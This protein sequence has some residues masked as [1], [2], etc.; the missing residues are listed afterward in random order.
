MRPA[1]R[2]R[3]GFIGLGM[4]VA[5]GFLVLGIQMYARIGQYYTLL[6]VTVG[7]IILGALSGVVGCF[8]VLRHQSLMGDTL[9]HAALPGVGI[10]F[11][12]SG[13]DLGALLVGAGIASWLGAQFI[14]LV[15]RTTRIKQDAAMGI[16]LAAWFAFGIALLS[17]IQGRPDASQSGLDKFIFGQAAAINQHDIAI[18]LIVSAGILAIL[19]AFWKEFKLFTFDPEFAAANGFAAGWLNMLLSSCIV[20]V[21]VLGLQVAGVVLVAGML[22]APGAAARQWTHRLGTMAVLAGSFGAFS[23]GAGAILSATDTKLPTGPLIIVIA[24]LLVF[25]SIAFAPERGIIW[26]WQRNRRD[27]RQ[28]AAQQVLADLYRYALR[29]GQD[30]HRPVPESFLVGIRGP[31]ARGV[32][33]QLETRSL[34]RHSDDHWSLSERGLAVVLEAE[35]AAPSDLRTPKRRLDQSHTTEPA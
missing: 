19:I 14:T 24:S 10:A 35:R 5:L 34:I 18:M 20:G 28:F 22:V 1:A 2:R 25:F 6:V 9:A 12:L 11:L 27:R 23:G 32:L 3:I 15:T 13:R 30:P 21:I 8:A 17:Y 29:H 26:N 16:V 7:G 4:L 33:Y 31:S